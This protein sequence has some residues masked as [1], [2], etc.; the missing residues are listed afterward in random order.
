MLFFDSLLSKSFTRYQKILSECSCR[1]KNILNFIC[2]TKKFYNIHCTSQQ[3]GH[4]RHF[5]TDRFL[6]FRPSFHIGD[7]DDFVFDNEIPI[8]GRFIVTPATA[9]RKS[10][11]QLHG[12]DTSSTGSQ[13]S[14]SFFFL[15]PA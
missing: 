5:C 9:R 8:N 15:A 12:T 14:Q 7:E 13:F 10:H 4:A 11:H 2:L 3:R 1:Y 6:S